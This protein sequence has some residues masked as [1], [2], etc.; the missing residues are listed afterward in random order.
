[1]TTKTISNT[2]ALLKDPTL[3]KTGSYIN[4]EWHQSDVTFDV[5][6]PYDQSLLVSVSEVSKDNDMSLVNS[7]IGAAKKA[8]AEWQSKTAYERYDLMMAWFDL[9]QKHKDD[10]AIIMTLEQGKPLKESLGEVEYGASYVRW[11]AEEGKRIYGDTIPALAPNQTITVIKQPVGV[12]AA[13]TPWNFPNS[14]LARKIA[15]AIAAG[16]T[17]VARPTELTPLSA[18]VLAELAERAG[19]PKGVINIVVGSNAK[20]IGEVLT[21]HDDVDKFSFTGSTNVGKQLMKQC[22]STVKKVSFELGGNAPFIVFDDADIDA[23][24]EGAI[25]AKF[26]NA[27]QTCVCVN[28]ILVHSAVH[29]EFVEKFIEQTKLLDVGNGLDDVDIGPLIHKQAADSVRE[30]VA[31]AIEQG[32]T[33]SYGQI[34]SDTMQSPI[35]LTN[36]NNEMEIAQNEIFGPVA[37]IQKFETEKQAVQLAND[38]PFGLASYFYSQNISRVER[39]SRALKY[40]IVGVNEGLISNAAAPFGGVKQSGFGREGSLYGLDDYLNIKYICTTY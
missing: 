39:V 38:T 31:S 20:E 14:M 13:I 24:V 7:A 2:K 15:P 28:R 12:V 21:T 34:L 30:L 29:D 3:V 22:A 4:G 27:G 9:M 32:A 35:V 6:N 19:V 18:L 33:Q 23:A 25:K 26:R 11:F 1:M 10:L 40:G 17:I 5:I 16:N 37:A 8:Q 36:V